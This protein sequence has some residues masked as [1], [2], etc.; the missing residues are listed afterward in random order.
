[1]YFQVQEGLYQVYVDQM[2]VNIVAVTRHSP[3]NH[4]TVILVAHT[5]FQNPEPNAGPSLVR[6]L[7]FEGDLEEIIFEAELTHK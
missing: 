7:V 1:M 5:S 2:D 6:P 4:Q 3:D